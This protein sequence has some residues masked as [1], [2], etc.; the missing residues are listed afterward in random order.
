MKKNKLFEELKNVGI[1]KD[2]KQIVTSV[3]D[4]PYFD[5]IYTKTDIPIL[6]IAWSAD[7]DGGIPPGITMIAGES[8][9]F[10]SSLAILCV[11]AYLDEHPESICVFYDIE[12]GI[13]K[14]Y[15]VNAG[16]DM[17]RIMYLDSKIVKSIEDVKMDMVDKLNKIE[18]CQ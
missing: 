7:P 3:N 4:S 18:L 5:T 6:N 1:A 16:I 2:S 15:F 11:K 13:K 10:K 9:T 8:K 12:K 14:P 17:D